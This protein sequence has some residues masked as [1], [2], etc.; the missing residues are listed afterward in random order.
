MFKIVKYKKIEWLKNNTDKCGAQD[1][2][3]NNLKKDEICIHIHNKKNGRMWGAT[4]EN[5]LLSIM[6]KNIG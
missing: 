6:N 4:N 3:I 5:H 1:E 2:I